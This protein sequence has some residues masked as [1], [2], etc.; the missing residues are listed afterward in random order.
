[1][2]NLTTI[3]ALLA[4]AC[5]ITVSTWWLLQLSALPR[6]NAAAI[7]DISLQAARTLLLLQLMS[8]SLF[9]PLWPTAALGGAKQPDASAHIVMPVLAAILPAWPLL[10]LLWLASGIAATAVVK[11]EVLVLGVGLAVTLLARAIHRLDLNTEAE[12]LLQTSLGIAAAAASWLFRAE[13]LQWIT[14]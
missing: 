3:P 11:I 8:I 7:N 2:R 4:I 9:A 6:M 1:M 14:V 12:R 5:L 10:A 13:W